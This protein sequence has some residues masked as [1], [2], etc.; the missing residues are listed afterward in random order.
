MCVHNAYQTT[1][2]Y[3]II[4]TIVH[5]F[6]VLDNNYQLTEAMN[7]ISKKILTSSLNQL[8]LPDTSNC[9]VRCV[10]SH[11]AQRQQ[12]SRATATHT[13]AQ[14]NNQGWEVSGSGYAL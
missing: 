8:Q 11:P 4:F 7:P 9:E 6:Y 3:T 13:H 10:D 12:L 1:N 14:A 5:T 2:R